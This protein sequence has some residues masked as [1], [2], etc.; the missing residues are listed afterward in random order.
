M[1]L[2]GRLDILYPDGQQEKHQLRGN[3]ITVGSAHSCSIQLA[4]V[5]VD[6]L[7]FRLDTG[8]G[9]ATITDL[10]SAAGTFVDG[11]RLPANTPSPLADTTAIAIGPLQLT[12]YRQSDSPTISMPALSQ[13]TQPA[14]AGFRARLEIVQTTV[15]PASSVTIPLSITN[16]SDSDAEFRIN[17]SGL[18]D[19]WVKPERLTF[20]LPAQEATQVQFLIKPGRR[21]D[22]P[23]QTFPLNITIR[24]LDE[25]QQ[26]LRLVGIIQLGGFGGLSLALEP[27]VCL[28]QGSFNLYLLN[29]GNE[30]LN[31][32]LDWQD[33]ASKLE[34]Q[35]S[36]NT[37]TL[38]PGS[39][40]IVTGG[41]KYRGRPLVGN[42]Q[43]LPFV[44]IAKA[45]NPTGYRVPLPASVRIEPRVSGRLA[46]L[47][48]AV[49]IAAVIIAAL[50]LFQPPEPVISSLAISESQVAGGTPVQL[51]WNAQHAQRY[52]IEVDR[53][54]VADLP[55][56]ASSY[57]LDTR[58]YIDPVN[59][60]LIAQGGETTAIASRRLDIY[61]PVAINHFYSD[62]TSMLRNVFGALTIRW[63]VDGAV[64]LDLAP[65]VDFESVGAA[66][67]FDSSGELA[68]RGA[69]P[70]EFEIILSATDEIGNRTRRVIQI[71]VR[72]PECVPRGD[73]LLYAGPDA[74]Y[75]QVSVAI[76]NV[77]VLVHGANKNRDWLQ[78]ESASGQIGWGDY[79]SFLCQD[80]APADLAIITD[81]PALPTATFTPAPSATAT[82]SPT[83]AFTSTPTADET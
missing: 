41:I 19:D 46:A 47:L 59:I 22:I 15:F 33:H 64:S 65:P 82:P 24:R 38:P 30:S 12:F 29:Q 35:L 43:E 77:S 3:E 79:A 32:A 61:K 16:T 23:P 40:S 42:P 48:A 44:L 76:E 45:E 36:Q 63:A 66:S 34:L 10:N 52:V 70:A 37:V 72:D 7:H 21:S 49:I 73:V 17:V 18:P 53:V 50:I 58:E 56:D 27:Q 54:P 51:S 75:A 11:Q 71:S 69:P 62:R 68:L 39:R 80:F 57:I 25:T 4:H 20:P 26:I 81:I 13:Q 31:L 6:N 8:S 5:A 83:P 78:V 2:F 67:S 28:D 60:A 74:R 9:G 14:V 55:A 1:T